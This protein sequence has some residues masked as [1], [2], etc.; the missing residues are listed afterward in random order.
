MNIANMDVLSAM[1]KATTLVHGQAKMRA[2]ADTGNLRAS[3]SMKV[4]KNNNKI[5]GRVYTNVNYAPFVEFGTGIKGDGSYP[6]KVTGLNLTYKDK[7]WVYTPDGGETFYRT[8]GHVAQPYMYPALKE[9]EKTI[10]AMFKNS[11]K[12]ELKNNCQGG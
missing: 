4:T 7:P 6:Y 8:E 11:V 3:I 9:N 10:K 1:N 5:Q 2:P 12:A